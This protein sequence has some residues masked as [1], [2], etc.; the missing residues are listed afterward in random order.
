MD[1][2]QVALYL[3]LSKE[4]PKTIRTMQSDKYG[5]KRESNSITMQKILLEKYAAE[6]FTDYHLLVFCDDGYSGI[7]F[8]RP[9]MQKMLNMVREGGI[10]CILVKDFSRFARDYIALGSYLERFFPFWGVRFIS[11][12]DH[13]DS[14][15][16]QGCAMGMDM[17]FKNLLCDL[18]SKDLS[19]KVRSSLAVRKER[20]EYISANS[21]FGYEKDPD[22]RHALLIAQDEAK[23]VRQIFSLSLDGRTSVEIAKKLNESGVK[24][25]LAFRVEKGKTSR[26]P[27]G[28]NFLWSSSMVCQILHNEVYIGK[29]VQ[30]KYTKDLAGGKNRVNPHGERLVTCHHHEPIIAK[31]VF[32]RV[33]KRFGRK[34]ADPAHAR[35]PLVGRLICGCCKKNLCY[36]NGKQPYYTCPQRYTNASDHCVKKVD[37]RCLEQAVLLMMH[38]RHPIRKELQ[39]QAAQAQELYDQKMRQIKTK[40]RF[41]QANIQNLR[42]KKFEA[43]QNYV[44]GRTIRF[45]TMEEK[46]KTASAELEQLEQSM[47]E[48]EDRKQ[49]LEKQSMLCTLHEDLAKQYLN[50]IIVYPIQ[51]SKKH[52]IEIYWK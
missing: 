26:K 23:V 43:Y 28:G 41:L 25:P 37:V 35:H 32:D 15:N 48:I 9:G 42:Q 40:R 33:Q 30:K 16:Y 31:D 2:Y 20:G 47:Q 44:F 17:N 29:I 5:K 10:D 52:I 18:Y 36:R 38:D 51:Q 22:N 46:E 12:N 39:K 6:N 7:H 4:D 34:K 13:Y 45:V 49:T 11:I 3:R 19:K 14:Q 27:K 8:E 50:K 24:T 21:P 1:T